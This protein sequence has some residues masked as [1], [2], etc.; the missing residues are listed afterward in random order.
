[1]SIGGKSVPIHGRELALLEVL[2][3]NAGRM[4]DRRTIHREIYGS[5]DS[6]APEA[7]NM[8]VERLR[9]WLREVR[10]APISARCAASAT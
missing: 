9:C 2:I 7:L 10:R 1:V 4:V 3:T 8:L 5:T 6:M